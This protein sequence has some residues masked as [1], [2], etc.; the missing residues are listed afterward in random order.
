MLRRATRIRSTTTVLVR[1]L[2]RA[3]STF[4]A[5]DRLLDRAVVV[6]FLPDEAGARAAVLDVARA[7]A[8]LA[9]PN[10]ARVHRVR[11]GGQRPYVVAAF[12]RGR[13]LDALTPPLPDTR[14]LDLGRRLAEALADL[15]AA[16][17]AHGGVVPERV[18]LS[19]DG[20]PRLVGLDLARA[21]ADDAA[22]RA[23][24]SD[25]LAVVQR[26]ASHELRA[27]LAPLADRDRGVATAEELRR[28][29]EALGR[30]VLS[31]EALDEN[32][33]RGLRA[34]EAQHAAVFFGRNREV[35]EL[36]ERL[37]VQP[38]LLVAGRSGAGKSSLARAG[39]APAIEGGALGE[40]EA[41]DVATMVP[42]AR[43]LEALA[44]ALAPFVDREPES[45]DP[46]L[47]EDPALAGRLARSRTGRGLLLVVDQLEETMTLASAEERGAFCAAL[48]RF[49]TLAPG[50]RVLF[51]LRARF[52]GR[53]PGAG[54][55]RKR[56]RFA[57]RTCSLR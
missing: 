42:G 2:G 13:T 3:G 40:R 56:S 41:W 21:G 36:V 4:L 35:G 38:W 48:E 27:R 44:R 25:L 1:P 32:P 11:E 46:A 37:R 49:G 34:F 50:V 17:V 10:L 39:I 30:P 31:P 55:V 22:R 6:S 5:H 43:P 28:A 53:A 24:V 54:S 26:L 12:A 18:I 20:T 14:V 7:F 52:P 9:H 47:G 23:D 8:R 51:T 45:L 33:Y 15:H 57:R 16:G 29:L 19:E